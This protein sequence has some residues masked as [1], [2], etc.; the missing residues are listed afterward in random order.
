V[1]VK[2]KMRSKVESSRLK[3]E[4][5]DSAETQRA[6]SKRREELASGVAGGRRTVEVER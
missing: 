4:E 1:E 2:T 6:L 5:K 3:E